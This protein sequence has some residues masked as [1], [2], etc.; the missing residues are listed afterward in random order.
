M[1]SSEWTKKIK[2][3][4]KKLEIYETAFDSVI[5]TLA[6][7]LEQRDLIYESYIQEGDEP[8]TEYTNKGG[9][10]NSV[11]NPKLKLW[12]ELNSSAL[13]YWKELG[14]TA[15]ALKKIRKDE[16]KGKEEASGLVAALAS[17]G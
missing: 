5:A 13:N 3:N 9:Q 17:I 12:N 10:V 6:D 8:I 16:P 11:L 2:S 14:L 15:S 1:K 4:M 7:I